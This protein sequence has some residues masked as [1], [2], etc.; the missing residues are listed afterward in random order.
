MSCVFGFEPNAPPRYHRHATKRRAIGSGF[1]VSGRRWFCLSTGHRRPLFFALQLILEK[2]C[3]IK[4]ICSWLV[5]FVT[6][7]TIFSPVW[8]ILSAMSKEMETVVDLVALRENAGLGVRELARQLGI[9]HT[10]I[11]KWETAG[12][13]AKADYLIPMSEILGVTIEELL[14]HP[15]PRRATAPGGKLGHVFRQV[16]EL[17]RRQQQR[18]VDVVEDMVT[19]QLSKKGA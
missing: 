19:A 10:T 2:S 16:S 12:K 5:I 4:I 15:K 18:I 11:L 1:V 8:C 3:Q 6:N 7:T 13:V 17:P 9:H 14:G